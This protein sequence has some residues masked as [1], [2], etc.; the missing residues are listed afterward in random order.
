MTNRSE[1]GKRIRP[2]RAW[3]LGLG[4]LGLAVGLLALFAGGDFLP[5]RRGIE[6]VP[7]PVAERAMADAPRTALVIGNGDYE[8][9]PLRNPVNDA[10]AMRDKLAELDFAVTY[11]ENADRAGMYEA[12]RV[13]GAALD[14]RRGVGLVYYAGHGMQVDGV[15]YLIPVGSGIQAENEVP[16]QAVA[17]DQILAKLESAGNGLNLVYLDACRNNPF[18]GVS[19]RARAASRGSARRRR[20]APRSITLPA[21]TGWPRTGPASTAPSPGTCSPPSTARA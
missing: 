21:P 19:A 13:F 8:T 18:A 3:L 14:A 11:R 17:L 4:A 5:A 12:M 9:A 15:N 10:R 2:P 7:I 16:Y 1:P 20:P 6:R